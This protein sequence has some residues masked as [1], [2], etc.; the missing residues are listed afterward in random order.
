LASSFEN[1][2][3]SADAGLLDADVVAVDDWLCAANSAFKVDG[4]SCESPLDPEAGGVK[5][6][7]AEAPAEK[8]NGFA[9]SW[10]R[11]VVCDEDDFDEVSDW[12]ASNADDTAPKAST[13]A[14]LRQIPHAR[15]LLP[16]REDQ[17]APCHHEKPNKTWVF[18]TS[19]CPPAPGN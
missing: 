11:P 5:L 12:R 7:E 4:D 18:R 10:P 14:E 3:W 8:S 17:Q 1:K 15:R 9:E 2:S 13:M 16:H 6:G 19:S